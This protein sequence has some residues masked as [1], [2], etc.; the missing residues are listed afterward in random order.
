MDST[1]SKKKTLSSAEKAALVVEFADDMKA[2]RIETLDVRAKTSVADYFIVCTGTSDTH[3]RSIAEKVSEN[4]RSS[5]IKALRRTQSTN[6]D[7]WVLYDFGDVIF[8]VMMEEKRQYYDLESFWGSMQS[9]PS[10]LPE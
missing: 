9:D 7:G 10:L 2:E 6:Q 1:K 4:L 8:H 3:V 5:G